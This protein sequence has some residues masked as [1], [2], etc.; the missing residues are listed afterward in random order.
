MKS[1]F[2][3]AIP[4]LGITDAH[5]VVILKGGVMYKFTFSAWS[6][7]VGDGSEQDV[8]EVHVTVKAETMQE[9]EMRAREEL[10]DICGLE[11]EIWYLKGLEVL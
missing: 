11:K 5:N 4:L 1:S 7:I 6:T 9:A 10:K 2:F 3:M 8:A